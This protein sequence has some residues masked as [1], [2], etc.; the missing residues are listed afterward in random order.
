MHR[1][2]RSC[3]GGGG[4]PPVQRA[5]SG[6]S[7]VVARGQFTLGSGLP[8][9]RNFSLASAS[10]FL[11]STSSLGI[12]L[13][14]CGVLA[15]AHPKSRSRQ[16]RGPKKGHYQI[17]EK[18][19]GDVVFDPDQRPWPP[20]TNGHPRRNIRGG[21]VQGLVLGAPSLAPYRDSS[22]CR[23]VSSRNRK[24]GSRLIGPGNDA[25]LRRTG[26]LDHVEP[27][28]PSARVMMDRGIPGRLAAARYER[29][30]QLQP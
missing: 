6:V 5:G 25:S 22:P 18:N 3:S 19:G 20:E 16:Q 1:V 28:G 26:D 21:Q 17:C 7:G 4:A 10:S 30:A 8:A 14:T 13:E 23:E 9:A 12:W 15:E 24:G 29:A 27:G 11:C 2:S